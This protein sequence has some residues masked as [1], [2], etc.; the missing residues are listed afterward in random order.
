MRLPSLAAAVLLVFSAAC[1]GDSSA[2]QA[3]DAPAVGKADGSDRADRG[4]QLVL[5]HVA[6]L[7]GPDGSRQAPDGRRYWVWS[8]EV[9]A[10]AAATEAGPPSILYANADAGWWEVTAEQVGVTAGGLIRYRFELAEATVEEGLSAAALSRAQVKL[11]PFVR[12]AAGGRLFDHN[13]IGD[14]LGTYVVDQASGWQVAAD[15]TCQ[16][17]AR[18]AGLVFA[19]DFSERQRGALVAGTRVTVDYNLGRLTTCRGTHNGFPAWDVIA[20]AR[21]EPSGAM[22][23]GTVRGFDAPGGVPT[24]GGFAV[25]WQFDVPAGATS[26]ALWFENTGIDCQ[27]WDSNL[28]ANY[29]FPVVAAPASPTWAGDVGNGFNRACEHRD[30]LANPMLLDSYIFERACM[31][32]DVDVYV[33]GLTDAGGNLDYVI[34]EAV[35]Q[36]TGDPG[37]ALVAPMTV[38]GRVGNNAR[39]RWQIDRSMFMYRSW[40]QLDATLRFSTDGVTWRTVG[41]QALT[42]GL[43]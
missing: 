27:V 12:A 24:G 28:S 18:Q 19:G 7:A 8:G 5:D 39:L 21:F 20:H 33:P 2:L 4:C 1:A 14:D 29:V 37:P 9:L 38:I 17:G 23:S 34:G 43:P 10:T 6:R 16:G 35:S 11:I 13:R 15:G 26:V 30:G 22:V 36:F 31:F 40:S 25:P 3:A 32:I 42:N 41:P